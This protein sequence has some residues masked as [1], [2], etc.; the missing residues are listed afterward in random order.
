MATAERGREPWWRPFLVP[1]SLAARLS[2][3][4]AA[5]LAVALGAVSTVRTIALK[6]ELIRSTATQIAVDYITEE[7]AIDY[8]YFNA[9]GTNL[10]RTMASPTVGALVV[11]SAGQVVATQGPISQQ[12]ASVEPPQMSQA[13]YLA[14]LSQLAARPG[15]DLYLTVSSPTGPQLLVI[16]PAGGGPF[17]LMGLFEL[18]TPLAPIDRTVRQQLEFDILAGLLALAGASA[19][20]YFLL[21]RFLAPLQDMAQ[22]SEQVARGDLAVEL[23]PVTGDDEVSRLSDA[24]GHM[25]RR[26]EAALEGERQEQRRMR[27]FLAD[28]SHSLRTPLTVLNGRL[29]LL[30]HGH[31]REGDELE[32]S[33]RDLR[34]EGERMARIVRGLLLLA[35]LEE[36]DSRPSAPSDV[37]AVLAGLGSR[38]EALAGERRLVV[39][40]APGLEAWATVDALETMTTNL[41]EN[42]ARHTPEGGT[43]EVCADAAD[44]MARIRVQDTGSGIAPDDLPHVF[45]RFYRGAQG[46]GRRDG[47]AG[48]GLS[49]VQRWAEALGGRVEAANRVDRRGAAFTIW[50]PSGAPQ[51]PQGASA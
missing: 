51:S 50:L 3:V 23:P 4:T 10:A 38:L 1:P 11:N 36:G 28:A 29:D 14:W 32:T 15:T 43:I 27:A 30:L 31:S 34:V 25:V 5:V 40:A 24:F 6:R 12:Y 26:I 37:A 20:I 17:G 19:A 47:G 49:I 33:L 42:A 16:E 46:G 45:D 39:R 22:A 41:V 2:L 44:G 8:R 9:P 48:L 18:A 21:G 7:P 13:Q 35:R